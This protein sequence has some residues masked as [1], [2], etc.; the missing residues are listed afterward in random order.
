MS[1]KAVVLDALDDLKANDVAVMHVAEM[2]S[3][4]DD[5]IVASGTS[6]RHVKSLANNVEQKAKESG[7]RPIGVEGGE[8]ADWVLVDFGELVVHIMLPATRAF[9]DLE[10]LWSVSPSSRAGAEKDN[11]GDQAQ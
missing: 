2:T 6:N 7:F 1:L 4:T 3:V 8:T 10:R 9:Y 5:M 11:S